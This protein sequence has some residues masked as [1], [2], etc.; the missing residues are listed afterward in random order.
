MPGSR[1]NFPKAVLKLKQYFRS[2]I[3]RKRF[4]SFT[5]T[6][7]IKKHIPNTLTCGNLFCGCLAVVFAFKGDLVFSS[8]LVGIAAVLDFFDGFAARLLNVH[9]EIGKQLD[10]L[11]DMVTFGVLP[12]VMMF[13]ML[14]D[15]AAFHFSGTFNETSYTAFKSGMEFPSWL[16]Y[17]AFM[18]TIF[19]ALRLA[20]FNIDTR[21]TSSFIGVPTPATAILIC[22]LPLIKFF[23]PVLGSFNVLV[24]IENPWFLLT[25]TILMSFLMVAELPLFALKFKN[26]GWADNKIRF[27]FLITAVIL[28]VLLKFIA[29]PFIIFLYI[30]LSLVNNITDKTQGAA[31]KEIIK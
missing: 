5:G 6:M 27:S 26:F 9:S 12:G 11:A 18:I 20:K 31:D 1:I 29:I 22:S 4:C 3:S 16:I 21:Q 14:A 7:N 13:L 19:S 10:S 23:Q 25:L 28:L 24:I 8:Y 30:I 2:F 15:A 17:T